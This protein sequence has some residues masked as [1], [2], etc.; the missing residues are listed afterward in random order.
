MSKNYAAS[1][2]QR[3]ARL[4]TAALLWSATAFGQTIKVYPVESVGGIMAGYD[5]AIWYSSV[6]KIGRIDPSGAITEFPTS[7]G[8][9]RGLAEDWDGYL[10][11]AGPER[12]SR[13][14]FP[15]GAVTDFPVPGLL[16]TEI[17]PPGDGVWFVAPASNLVGHLRYSGTVVTFPLPTPGAFPAGIAG[18]TDGN[19][20]FTE[21]GAH[22]IGRITRFGKLTEF[23]LPRADHFPTG[24]RGTW[25][26]Y[27]WFAEQGG[28][29]GR[30][31]PTGEVT[32]FTVSPQ[33]DDRTYAVES[34]YSNNLW[35]AGWG[36]LHRVTKSGEVTTFS[37]I[38]TLEPVGMAI[39]FNGDIWIAGR[40]EDHSQIV[41]FD[42]TPP[43]AR[44]RAVSR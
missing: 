9:N 2:C 21:S 23:D 16:P 5:G 37:P 8:Q 39:S 38:P 43:R 40:H 4:V 20:W 36:E 41:R 6:G 34:D 19:I 14:T 29:V 25:D 26:G 10:W 42:L 17:V 33:P 15:S 11:F 13:M 30:I 44:R 31:S 22:K 24:I 1:Q 12:I 32:E 28:R 7:P 3:V 35:F 27:L 18:G